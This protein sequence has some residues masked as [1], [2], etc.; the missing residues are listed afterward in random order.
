MSVVV[1]PISAIIPSLISANAE[2]PRTLA[3]GPDK[4]VS[5]GRCLTNEADTKE[6]SPRTTISGAF[7]ESE[8]IAVSTAVRSSWIR[9]I[10]RAFN[11]A[12]TARFGPL[13]CPD[14]SWLHVTGF[15]VAF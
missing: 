10:N 2:D 3:A 6:P 7:N 4:I 9:E 1:P 12:V 15:P 14:N 11:R 13:S 8:S 5:I